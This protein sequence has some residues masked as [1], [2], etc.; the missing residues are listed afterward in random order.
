MC[1]CYLRKNAKEFVVTSPHVCHVQ[2]YHES[3]M[4]TRNVNANMKR[5]PKRERNCRK[6]SASQRN[7]TT[8]HNMSH[9]CNMRHI[10]MPD[11]QI[12]KK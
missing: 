4:Q 2:S 5:E 11:D 6:T 1:Q 7:I 3:R 10:I 12:I 8:R 9:T